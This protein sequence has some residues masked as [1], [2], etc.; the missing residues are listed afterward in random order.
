[1]KKLLFSLFSAFVSY[2]MDGQSTLISQFDF[3][4]NYNDNLVTSTCTAFNNASAA[5]VNGAFTW[6]ANSTG[7]GGGL[8]V[9]VPDASFTENDYSISMDLK[10]NEV[11]NYVKVIDFKEQTNDNGLYFSSGLVELY[12]LGAGSTN[13]NSNT[14]YTVLLTRRAADDSVKVY[15]LQ[16]NQLLLQIF[17]KDVNSDYVTSLNGTDR[18]FSLFHDDLTT[19]T[20]YTDSGAVRSVR[21]WNGIVTIGQVCNSIVSLTTT[22]SLTICAGSSVTITPGGSPTTFTTYTFNP[23]NTVGNILTLT[24]ATTTTINVSGDY[25]STGCATPSTNITLSVNPNPTITA[26][27]S[28]SILC[29]GQQATITAN[30]ASSYA[31]SSG[32]NSSSVVV[33]PT[34]TTSYTVS[35][36]N[37]NCTASFVVT[38]TVTTCTGIPRSADENVILGLYPN[39]FN[40]KII[41]LS[42]LINNPVLII[43]SLGEIVYNT[44]IVEE[45]TELDLGSLSTGIYFIKTGNT[46][47]KIIKE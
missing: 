7:G 21:I 13:I 22:P 31:W 9:K 15:V 25:Y 38:Q 27:S 6:T 30:G 20:E 40:G 33:S 46:T 37:N 39:P 43:N 29:A 2:S 19:N 36:T 14:Y 34:V 17:D 8:I 26:V 44:I 10:F 11:T 41:L 1:M 5:F 18:V 16:N 4:S 42:S 35:G 3:N 23:P 47:K 12:P 24:P 28:A 45:K 32:P